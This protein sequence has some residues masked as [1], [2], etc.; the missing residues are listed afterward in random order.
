MLDNISDFF[1]GILLKF[2]PHMPTSN[3]SFDS[4]LQQLHDFLAHV[5][6][7]IPFYLF[8]P[9]TLGWFTVIIASFGILI[10]IRWFKGSV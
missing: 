6:Y 4:Y 5:N 8:A 7:F 2:I 1:G 10:F 3:F 9:I